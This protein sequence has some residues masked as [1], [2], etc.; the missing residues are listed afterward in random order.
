MSKSNQKSAKDKA[1]DRERIRLHSIIQQ[2]DDEIARL[3]RE[4]AKYKAEAESWEKTAKIL[5]TYIGI[6]KEE[7]LADIETTKKLANILNNI[8][9][10]IA[11]YL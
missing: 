5:E 9:H 1:F 3:N 6:P 2:R 8:P 7:I 10:N 4:V 11:K